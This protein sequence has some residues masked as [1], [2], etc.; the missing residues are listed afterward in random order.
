MALSLSA[1]G[2][3]ADA[4]QTLEAGLLKVCL[5]PGFAPF[6]VKRD[7]GWSG[8]DTDFLRDFAQRHHLTLTPV[9]VEHFDD[10]WMRPGDDQCDIAGTGITKTPARTQQTGT[11]AAWSDTYYGVARALAVSSGTTVTGIEDLA[12]KTVVTTRGDADDLGA[13]RI[14]AGGPDGPI[15]FAA[16]L[17]SVESILRQYPGLAAKLTHCLMLPGGVL[18][19]EHFGFVV[20][21]ASTGLLEA[22]NGYIAAPGLPYPGGPG[23]GLDCPAGQ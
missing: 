3:A 21:A 10:I 6:A 19:A 1:H 12:G 20:R 5:Y 4:P 7:H 18:S 15:G 23:S 16:G 9:E 8:W 17:G 2:A 14:A 11:A 22:L 13:Q